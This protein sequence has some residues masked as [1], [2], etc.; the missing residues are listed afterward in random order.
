M[1]FV[2]VGGELPFDRLIRA[3]DGWAAAHPGADL[4]AQIGAGSY[5]PA[6]MRWVRR[7]ERMAYAE[8]LH[9][10]ELIVAHAGMGSVL[11]AGESGKPIV[12]LPR[13]A[14]LREH[15]NDHQQDTALYLRD[16]AGIF[17]ADDETALP[18][19]ID[20]ALASAG[21]SIGDTA[22]EVFLERLRAFVLGGPRRR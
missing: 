9:A 6:H 16:H 10:A 22:P 8:T 19:R 18:A 3:M 14:R 11:S 15:R 12:L 4:L 5:Q 21:F 17:V 1:I 20:A 2:T 7:L 13:Q